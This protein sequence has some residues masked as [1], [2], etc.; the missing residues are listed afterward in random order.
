MV[1]VVFLPRYILTLKIPKTPPDPTNLFSR[2]V[3]EVLLIAI[4]NPLITTT[5]VSN[6]R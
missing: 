6:A 3:A 2:Q 1:Q 5:F 4:P